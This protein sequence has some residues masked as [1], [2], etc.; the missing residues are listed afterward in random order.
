MLRTP[1]DDRLKQ[2]LSVIETWLSL[3]QPAFAAA[4]NSNSEDDKE[5]LDDPDAF[6]LAFP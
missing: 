2:P 3:A 5:N 1:L 6:E 4:C